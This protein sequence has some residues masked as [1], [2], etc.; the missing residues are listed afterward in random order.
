[1]KKQSKWKPGKHRYLQV[2]VISKLSLMFTMSIWGRSLGGSVSWDSANLKAACSWDCWLGNNPPGEKNKTRSLKHTYISSPF[3]L[4][5]SCRGVSRD[6]TAAPNPPAHLTQGVHAC[7]RQAGSWKPSHYAVPGHTGALMHPE[8]SSP[9][10]QAEAQGLAFNLLTPP[11]T[12][13]NRNGS[14]ASA[15]KEESEY[16]LLLL[17]SQWGPIWILL[18]RLAPWGAQDSPAK[19]C[20]TLGTRGQICKSRSKQGSRYT[21]AAAAGSVKYGKPL[22]LTGDRGQTQTGQEIE[23]LILRNIHSNTSA[24]EPRTTGQH[25]LDGNWD[26]ARPSSELASLNGPGITQLWE[27]FPAAPPEGDLTCGRS[28]RSLQK[29][30]DTFGPPCYLRAF[31]GSTAIC[32]IEGGKQSTWK[33]DWIEIEKQGASIPTPAPLPSPPRAGGFGKNQICR[34]LLARSS[35]VWRASPRCVERAICARISPTPPHAPLLLPNHGCQRNW[36]L[37]A[38]LGYHLCLLEGRE[39]GMLRVFGV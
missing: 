6:A 13:R 12:L 8:P 11:I 32:M 3:G 24:K 25:K 36:K 4:K 37:V 35:S 28:L 26:Q 19:P 18:S 16:S 1:M 10:G 7:C 27:K 21:P 38:E 15:I 14:T 17:H 20:P 9:Q 5:Y 31:T 39:S 22:H 30:A 23:S 33:A 34:D 29:G 2:Y